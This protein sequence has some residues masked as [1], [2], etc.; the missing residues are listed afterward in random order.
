MIKKSVRHF[1]EK[2]EKFLGLLIDACVPKNVGKIII[3]LSKKTDATVNDFSRGIDLRQSD[4]SRAVNYMIEQ[5]WLRS[6][7]IPMEEK[8]YWFK[9]Y[10]HAMP[11]TE[12]IESIEKDN[13]NEACDQIKLVR[14]IRDS[15]K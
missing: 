15:F 2:E 12:I 11:L 7:Q 4:A 9:K 10:E 6:I 8:P 5:G 1:A 14:K 13:R 3:F